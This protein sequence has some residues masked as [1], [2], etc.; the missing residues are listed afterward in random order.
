[1]YA[2]VFPLDVYTLAFLMDAAGLKLVH[3]VQV[4]L[5]VGKELVQKGI[6]N[7]QACDALIE[8]IKDN[9]RWVDKDEVEEEVPAQVAA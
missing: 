2:L 1:M 7:E 8:L 3:A 6:P 5:Y 9:D 4:D